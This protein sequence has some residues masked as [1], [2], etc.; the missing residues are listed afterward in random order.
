M[1]TVM[2]TACLSWCTI[3]IHGPRLILHLSIY[4]FVYIFKVPTIHV[5]GEISFPKKKM[6][7]EKCNLSFFLQFNCA[8]SIQVCN[9]I[10]LDSPVGAGFSYSNTLQGYI[11]SDTKAIDQ[12]L[13]F[14]K[15][16][17]SPVIDLIFLTIIRNPN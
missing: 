15:K 16:V 17:T 2:W 7:M 4:L 12:I 11:S 6:Y 13:I 9:I 14:L 3:N 5:C 10:F 8:C 1:L